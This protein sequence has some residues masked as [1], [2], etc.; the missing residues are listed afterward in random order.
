MTFG[1]YGLIDENSHTSA[2]AGL[3]E[4]LSKFERHRVFRPTA[5]EILATLGEAGR[6]VLEA[7]DTEEKKR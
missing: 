5:R 1:T 2:A 3:A 6:C 7:W 4:Y